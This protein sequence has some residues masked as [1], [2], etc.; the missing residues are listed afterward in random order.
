[1]GIS[2]EGANKRFGDFQ[3]LDD[4]SINVPAGSFH[5]LL[6]ENG[7][8][9]S[10]LVKCILGFHRPDN[11]RL[12]VDG[13]QVTIANPRAAR[14]V[15]IGMVYQTSSLVPSLTAAENLV[16]ARGDTAVLDHR[17]DLYSVGVILY[18]LVTCRQPYYGTAFSIFRKVLAE[19]PPLPSSHRPDLDP[20]LEQMILK[21]MARPVA[22]R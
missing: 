22:G 9:K 3:A 12:M 18:E 16:L 20:A 2:V 6:G 13:M 14:A 7:A 17:A 10:T 15:G 8:V 11:G 5:A 21:A 4:V 1:M 19:D